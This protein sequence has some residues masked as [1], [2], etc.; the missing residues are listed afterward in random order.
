MEAGMVKNI[1][2]KP[3]CYGTG[4]PCR[5]SALNLTFVAGCL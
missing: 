1:L 3:V 2:K 4:F 5:V